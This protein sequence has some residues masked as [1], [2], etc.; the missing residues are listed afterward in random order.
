MNINH[1]DTCTILTGSNEQYA[2]DI[3]RL[4]ENWRGFSI[5]G[6]TTV[7]LLC[8]HRFVW[9][10]TSSWSVGAAGTCAKFK[11]HTNRRNGTA[12]V[13]VTNWSTIAK[14][15]E[16]W[17]QIIEKRSWAEKK[18]VLFAVIPSRSIS[19]VWL[20]RDELLRMCAK[21][22]VYLSATIVLPYDSI[23]PNLSRIC[24]RL[25]FSRSE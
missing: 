1:Y 21:G 5:G 11:F 12:T 4:Y 25:R 24:W 17:R 18:R 6:H 15:R 7:P 16:R 10:D 8:V 23:L 3:I 19:L 22:N 2:T 13:D 9:N 14:Y 20:E